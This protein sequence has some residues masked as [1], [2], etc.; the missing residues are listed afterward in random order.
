MPQDY[1]QLFGLP[2]SFDVDL[3]LLTSRYRELQ[4]AVH[5]DRFANAT[6][7]ERR[8]AMERASD[9]NQGYRVL[10]E[11]IERALHLLRL[12]GVNVDDTTG[13][14]VEPAFLMEQMELRETLGAI[15]A[16]K[17][18]ST[19]LAD[20]FAAIERLEAQV[21]A[22]LRAS[23]AQGGEALRGAPRDVQK[24][25]FVTKLRAEA[26]EIEEHLSD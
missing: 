25:R 19:E 6:A 4:R 26:R 7:Q 22:A 12:N 18:G 23:F 13:A 3:E 20:V 21:V 24:L 9:V 11:P 15:R 5:P 10:K 16:G 17:A 8:L 14:S 2:S 1:F